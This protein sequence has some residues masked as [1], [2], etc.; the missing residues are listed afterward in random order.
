MRRG[1]V[2]QLPQSDLLKS[3]H[4][5]VSDFYATLVPPSRS[6]PDMENRR[7]G[8]EI[9][10]AIGT[11]NRRTSQSADDLSFDE[12]ALLA[13]G[14]LVEEMAA[15]VLGDTGDLVFVEGAEVNQNP[16]PKGDLG[17]ETGGQS[18][19]TV[20]ER[21][22][23]SETLDGNYPSVIARNE[24]AVKSGQTR[25]GRKVRKLDHDVLKEKCGT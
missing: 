16:L 24:A 9:D 18:K 4:V 17:N 5:Y 2:R 15:E 7:N 6:E 19:K 11:S 23:G 20:A 22:I 13:M 10:G 3:M 21:W 25:K 8:E 1:K 14:I 12:T